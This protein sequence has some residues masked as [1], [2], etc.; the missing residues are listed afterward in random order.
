M[1]HGGPPLH[2]QADR[3]RDDLRRP[4]R[5]RDRKRA[6][7]EGAPGS[8]RSADT[9]GRGAQ[10]PG[11][12]QPGRQLHARPR[13]RAGDHRQSGCP[14]VRQLQRD[15]LRVRRGHAE[16]PRA[17]NAPDHTRAPANATGDADPARRGGGRPGR[18]HPG[19]RRGRQHRRRAARGPPGAR[20]SRPGRHGLAR[21]DSAGQGRPVAR[22]PGDRASRARRVLSGD[23]YH[24]SDLRRPV[25]AGHPERPPLPRSRGRTARCRDRQRGQERVPRHDES[26]DPDPHERGDRDERPLAEHRADRGAARLRGDRPLERG[27]PADRHQ[28][29]V[30]LQ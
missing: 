17:G 30:G 29:R 6:T 26:R 25:G 15:R 19:T 5:H 4:G 18:S 20:D 13:N 21:R 22:R 27:R 10:G 12:G 24:A 11:G 1:A 16:L 3:P 14:A 23:R 7:V 28:R 8:N 2:R 9:F